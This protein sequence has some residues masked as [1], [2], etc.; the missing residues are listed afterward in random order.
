MSDNNSNAAALIALDWGTSSLRAFLLAADGA[1]LEQ[2]HRPWGIS[3]LPEGGYPAAFLQI[4]ADW[5]IRDV[6]LIAS[7]MV[8]SR[9]GWKQIEYRA[10]PADPSGLADALDSVL[11]PLPDGGEI[12]VRLV[13]GL[14]DPAGPD[15]MRGEETEAIGALDALGHPPGPLLLVMPGTHSK[16][17]RVSGGV[18]EGFSTF[19]TG[20]LF[21]LLNTRSILASG[22]EPAPGT[23]TDTVFAEAVRE[24]AET[25]LAAALFRTRAR[26]LTGAL[27]PAC[28]AAHLSGLLIGEELTAALRTVPQ[29]HSSSRIVLVG[30]PALTARYRDAFAALGRKAP[31]HLQAAALR[32]LYRIAV[33]AG[34]AG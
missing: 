15:V 19:M 31:E 1:V 2:R 21:A 13:P 22:A 12:A 3:S 29:S 24:A 17:L 23:A 34:L 5:P 25:G 30:D 10:L 20:E 14:L 26:M 33:S 6:P 27:D 11:C 4:A 32:G 8:G 9:A 18:V 7:G 16:W 28:T